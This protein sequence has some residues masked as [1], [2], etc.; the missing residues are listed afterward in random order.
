MDL[1]RVWASVVIVVTCAAA[2]SPVVPSLRGHKGDS[3]PL[4]WYP[5]FAKER[6]EYERPTYVFATT[7]KGKRV[8]VD[9]S[10]WSSGG[11]NQGRNE[12]TTTVKAG[13][14]R[15]DAMCERIAARV[16]ERDR[17]ALRAVTELTVAVGKYD[18]KRYFEGDEEPISERIITTCPVIR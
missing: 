15:I 1:A 13:P 16:V 4:S 10:Y 18:R 5:M 6:P 7:P 9:V 12:L 2:I 17:R 11:F 8:K 3:F 14:D